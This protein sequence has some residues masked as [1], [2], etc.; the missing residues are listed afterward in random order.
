MHLHL[1]R[2]RVNLRHLH[3]CRPRVNLRHL[4]FSWSGVNLR[5]INFFCF[6]N[7]IFLA[8]SCFLW[9]FNLLLIFWFLSFLNFIYLPPS[10]LRF[11]LCCSF[12][13]R[14]NLYLFGLAFFNNLWLSPS[15]LRFN[16]FHFFINL[17]ILYIRLWVRLLLIAKDVLHIVCNINHFNI[18]F[19]WLFV[20]LA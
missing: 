1:C 18:L 3:L 2:P 16:L 4:N 8:P 12:P 9:W 19:D 6:F 5:R 10:T 14:L 11:F 20:R 13:R 17:L 7:N 15:F